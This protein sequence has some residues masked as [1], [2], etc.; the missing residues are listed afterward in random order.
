MPEHRSDWYRDDYNGEWRRHSDARA[1]APGPQR[2]SPR[3]ERL[4]DFLALAER[5]PIERALESAVKGLGYDD[6]SDLL[7]SDDFDRAVAT[8]SLTKAEHRSL[9]AT[10]KHLLDIAHNRSAKHV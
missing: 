3:N 8:V 6:M 2:Y 7:T 5:E 4:R 9:L 1:G 10:C